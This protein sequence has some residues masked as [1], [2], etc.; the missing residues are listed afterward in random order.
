VVGLEEEELQYKFLII[1][2]IHEDGHVARI[3]AAIIQKPLSAE[4]LSTYCNIPTEQCLRIIRKLKDNGLI[5]VTKKAASQNDPDKSDFLY[6][7]KLDQ[8]IIRFENGR[9]KMVFPAVFR[10]TNGKKIVVKDM[11]KSSS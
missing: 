6:K 1:K 10:L 9:F 5:R 7:A 4:Q 11:V 3:L 2:L 8:K